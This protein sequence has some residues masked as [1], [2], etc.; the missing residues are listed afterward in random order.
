MFVN[1]GQISRILE[2]WNIGYYRECI[3]QARHVHRLQTRRWYFYNKVEWKHTEVQKP[4]STHIEGVTEIVLYFAKKIGHLGVSQKVLFT[5]SIFHDT[6]EDWD[7]EDIARIIDYLKNNLNSAELV[8]VIKII[9]ALSKPSSHTDELY[10]LLGLKWLQVSIIWRSSLD[11]A[12]FSE[13]RAFSILEDVTNKLPL[14]LEKWI[15]NLKEWTKHFSW[16]TIHNEFYPNHLRPLFQNSWIDETW[17]VRLYKFVEDYFFVYWQYSQESL[18]DLSG[19]KRKIHNDLSAILQ[20]MVF[21]K[22]SKAHDDMSDVKEEIVQIKGWDILYNTWDNHYLTEIRDPEK[23]KKYVKNT[24]LLAIR[25]EFYQ[26]ILES[27]FEWNWNNTIL[28]I[29]RDT[30]DSLMNIL[31]HAETRLMLSE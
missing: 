6:F 11:I 16:T 24:Q 22:F 30:R 27:E 4:Y 5:A 7:I 17:Q 18:T 23:L 19:I 31:L 12:K 20:I 13:Y 10:E 2:V 9:L 3:K 8:Q 26:R 14:L 25:S 21:A 15:K 29:F 28:R 1:R